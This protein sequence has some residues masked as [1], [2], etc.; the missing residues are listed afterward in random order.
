MWASLITAPS[1]LLSRSQIAMCPR[2]LDEATVLIPSRRVGGKRGREGSEVG[3]RKWEERNVRKCVRKW[4]GSGERDGGGEE[5]RKRERSNEG[6]ER[7][8]KKR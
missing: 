1:R 3:A 6:E 5:E 2:G 8:R 4:G 7:R